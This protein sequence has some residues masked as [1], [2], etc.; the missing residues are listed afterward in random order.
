ML[1]RIKR[2]LA[3]AA[4][5]CVTQSAARFAQPA[6][7]A[8]ASAD[9]A[10]LA[11]ATCAVVENLEGRT[12]LAA[13]NLGIN[14]NEASSDM[15]D[16]AIPKLKALGVKSVRIWLGTDFKSKSWEGPMQRC[17]DYAAAGF[18]VMAVVVPRNGTIPSASN[19]KSWFNWAMDTKLKGAVDRWQIGN[20][21][22]HDR[23]WNG[24]PVSYVSGLLKPAAEVL[25]PEG[26]DVVSA[27]PSWNPEDVR[28]M[29]NAGMLNYV[30]YVGY[31]PY[32]TDGLMKTRLQ[33]IQSV[34]AGRKPIVASEWNVRG[35]SDQSDWA[36]A[37]AKN[38]PYVQGTFAQNY[39]FA[40]VQKYNSMAGP[41]G[42]LT[43]SGSPTKFYYALQSQL[44]NKQ[45]PGGSTGSTPSATTTAPRISGLQI[46]DAAT[47]R[48][49]S[50]YSNITSSTTIRLSSLPTRNIRIA[51]I[52]NSSTG[53]VKL[54]TFGKTI[55]ENL[56]P[57]QSGAWY[58]KSG[59]YA[60]SAT[61]YQRD[62]LA[63]TVGNT[64]RVTLTFA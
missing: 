11:R 42:I 15:M 39:Y 19:V 3:P 60:V 18:D 40:L 32:S 61:A 48:V 8:H 30:D 49:I 45:S 33:Q 53:S 50:G 43:S 22:D 46:V 31:H 62:N 55:T 59:S 4:P 14:I 34:V 20:E 21:P 57:Y 63:G 10:P 16:R 47:G 12:L 2:F 5:A 27:G 7:P 58:A 51:A 56:A 26:E 41:G 6:N 9:A 23:Y 13:F 44:G 35:I 38:F 36:D 17:V 28:D 54:S 64:V 29:I 37:V 1:N 52:A 25:R 24:S